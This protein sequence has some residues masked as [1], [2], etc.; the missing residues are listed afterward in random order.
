MLFSRPGSLPS[1]KPILT[2]AISLA[3]NPE[4]FYHPIPGCP[5]LVLTIGGFSAQI[6]VLLLADLLQTRV[7]ELQISQPCCARTD[8]Q[9][10]AFLAG[11]LLTGWEIA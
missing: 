3:R 5:R 9:Y 7:E 2:A 11:A 10:G 6:H 1:P 8:R 4:A